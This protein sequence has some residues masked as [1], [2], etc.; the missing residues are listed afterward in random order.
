MRGTRGASC[1]DRC[2]EKSCRSNRSSL[3]RF[4][5]YRDVPGTDTSPPLSPSRRERRSADGFSVPGGASRVR[6]AVFVA[7]AVF[8]APAAAAARPAPAA[9]AWSATALPAEAHAPVSP[10]SLTRPTTIVRHHAD[11]GLQATA[12]DEKGLMTRHGWRADRRSMTVVLVRPGDRAA[13]DGIRGRVA[14]RARTSPS[15][16]EFDAADRSASGTGCVSEGYSVG[17]GSGARLD[18]PAGSPPVLRE[19]AGLQSNAQMGGA[20]SR[21]MTGRGWRTGRRMCPPHRPRPGTLPR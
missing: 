3:K 15:S 20:R 16:S 8:G 14:R 18:G 1:P 10:G 19:R 13:R 4:R 5:S 9:A 12:S 11:S 17:G 21:R 7:G 6:G 2:G